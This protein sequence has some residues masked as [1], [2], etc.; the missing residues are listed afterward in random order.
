MLQHEGVKT[1]NRFPC[2]LPVGAGHADSSYDVT[3][4]MGACVRA[5]GW[6]TGS[7]TP[8]GVL[9]AGCMLSA[10]LLLPAPQE[11]QVGF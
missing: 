5:E 8:L 3:V 11:W 6:L 10:L 4:G 9:C 7:A 2:S 1:S